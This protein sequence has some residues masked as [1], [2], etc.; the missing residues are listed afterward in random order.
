MLALLLFRFLKRPSAVP[1]L[2][3]LIL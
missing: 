1:V 3:L 2:G